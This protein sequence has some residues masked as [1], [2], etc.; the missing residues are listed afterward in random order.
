MFAVQAL[1]PG[2]LDHEKAWCILPCGCAGAS[3]LCSVYLP[4]G[5][6]SR[7]GLPNASL[8]TWNLS[9]SMLKCFSALY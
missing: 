2:A 6:S 5:L 9:L 4:A 3:F 1:K 8:N 7:M